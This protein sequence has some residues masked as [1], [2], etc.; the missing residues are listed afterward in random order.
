[1]NDAVRVLDRG[2]CLLIF[3][4]GWLARKP[5]RLRR[6]APGVWRSPS[7]RPDTPVVCCW[8]EG[9][10]GSFTSHFQGPP[11]RN[12]W[13]DFRRRIDVGVSTPA[14]LD[15]AVLEDGLAT[16]RPAHAQVRRHRTTWPGAACRWP[17]RACRAR[18]WPARARS[19]LT[20]SR[21]A[22]ACGDS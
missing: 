4:E 3:P 19:R 18:P 16:R 11:L 8:I 15:P 2:E 21:P 7:T 5:G 14:V 9:G 1:M 6:F 22:H 20:G 12:K 13:P 17:S 10:W